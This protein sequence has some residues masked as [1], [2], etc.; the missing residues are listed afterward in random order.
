MNL[1]ID[2][3]G[4][5]LPARHGDRLKLD[6]PADTPADPLPALKSWRY[7]SAAGLGAVGRWVFERQTDPNQLPGSGD[8]VLFTQGNAVVPS[9]Q[10]VIDNNN[11]PAR[12]V[13]HDLDIALLGEVEGRNP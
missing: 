7:I 5:V 4:L 12:E 3:P 13:K 8:N 10:S 6:D 2:D 1:P 11:N 9:E